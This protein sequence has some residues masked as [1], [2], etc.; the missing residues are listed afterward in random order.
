MIE[1]LQ[2]YATKAVPPEVFK[3]EDR[4]TRSDDSE[5]Y[6][7]RL[8]VAAFVTEQG[9]VDQDHRP[10]A[11]TT[12]VEVVTPGDRRF[13]QAGRAGEVA[14][15]LAA[16]Q[17]ASSGPGNAALF[18]GDQHTVAVAGEV[19]RL[20]LDLAGASAEADALA[21]NLQQASE[22]LRAEREAHNATRNQIGNLTTNLSAAEAARSEAEKALGVERD[23]SA[24]LERQ[25]AEATKPPAETGS[26]Q[27]QGEQPAAKPGKGK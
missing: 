2:D 18:G 13:A 19:E 10:V 7:V 3:R 5:A 24:D 21:Q 9:L 14:I 22:D 6:F 4:V 8:G 1:F 23:R 27:Q 20:T 15:G 11:A 12:L 26:E 25:L 17:R 16:P